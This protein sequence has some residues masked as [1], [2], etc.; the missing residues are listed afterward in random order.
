MVFKYRVRGAWIFAGVMSLV[1]AILSV[2]ML[3]LIRNTDYHTFFHS[4]IVL[5]LVLNL[6]LSFSYFRIQKIDYVRLDE[7]SI[8]IHRGF[9]FPRE[10]VMMSDVG[11]VNIDDDKISIF[12][13][14][15]NDRRVDLYSKFI[16]A[17]DFEKLRQELKR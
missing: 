9:P 12:I 8:S 7:D 14:G 10:K 6:F 2:I 3:L 15:K 17:N 4:L 1:V 16:R 11:N 13:K 5:N